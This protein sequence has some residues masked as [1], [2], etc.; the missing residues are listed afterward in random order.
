VLI[1]G[2]I[3]LV[4]VAILGFGL[5]GVTLVRGTVRDLDALTTKAESLESGDLDVEL[6]TDRADE[7]H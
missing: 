7:E 3:G 1:V 4:G 2:A 6:S 5:I